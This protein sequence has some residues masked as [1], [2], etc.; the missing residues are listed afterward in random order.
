[1]LLRNFLPLLIATIFLLPSK[2]VAQVSFSTISDKQV[3][4]LTDLLQVQ[5]IAENATD[6]S[7]FK[8]P[9]FKDFTVMQGP[10]ETSGM[11]IINGEVSRYRALT[12][13]LRPNKK[14]RLTIPGATATINGKKMQSNQLRIEVGEASTQPSHPAP[15][16]VDP[17]ANPYRR[18]PQEEYMLQPGESATEKI[19]KNLLV[20]LD[21]DKTTA[22]V[23]E[24]IVATYKLL[25]RLRSDS[26]I[27]KRP[28]L[29][30]F[31]VYD[32]VEYDGSGPTIEVKDGKEYQSHLIRKTQLFPL[33]EGS[34]VLE[35][36]ELE[37]NVRFL[38]TDQPR[39]NSNRSGLQRLID[40]LMGE[41][42]GVWE[43]HSVNIASTPRTITVLPL[44]DNAPAN[45]SGAVGQF[46]IKGKPANATV[47]AGENII[48]ELVI[49]GGG[50]IPLINAPA[51]E[52]PEGFTLFDPTVK[53]E[54]DK[55]VSP[56][57]GKKIFTYTFTPEREGEYTVP[58][59]AFSYFDPNSKTYKSLSTDS[60]S[61]TVTPAL[62]RPASAPRETVASPNT[63]NSTYWIIGT[64]VLVMGLMVWLLLTKRKTRQTPAGSKY[65]GAD[66]AQNKPEPLSKPIPAQPTPEQVRTTGSH[67]N[68]PQS[69][70]S[71][72]KQGAVPGEE[73]LQ[74]ARGTT[75]HPGAE[76]PK[77]IDTNKDYLTG[78]RTALEQEDSAAFYKEVESGL[79]QFLGDQLQLPPASWQKE[80]VIRLLEKKGC[81]PEINIMLNNIWQQYEWARYAPSLHSGNQ[82]RLMEETEA[83]I[84]QIRDSLS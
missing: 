25:T 71:T 46:T 52:L 84:R 49:D 6:I 48:Y 82:T 76:L 20:V 31:S 47:A 28:S 3:I 30:G 19:K 83:V 41:E 65:P 22:Y 43:E 29:N 7:D 12:Y 75:G 23:G 18:Q 44:P 78:A 1:M 58:G 50:N 9:S 26:R 70:W 21:L 57:R 54:L 77:R 62:N 33:Q 40:D 55:T 81:S 80:T 56:M 42:S 37:N 24:P 72:P 64:G 11:S 13:I 4:G 63:D 5:F 10:I 8:V 17:L 67:D 15:R 2:L 38:R 79:W 59:I 74:P 53:E 36:V 51:W 61:I 14:G 69:D 60:F 39:G 68:A 34:F 73:S 32:M 35:P 16:P 27:S 66:P 45:F